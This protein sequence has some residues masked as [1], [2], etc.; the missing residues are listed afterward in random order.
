MQVQVLAFQVVCTSVSALEQGHLSLSDC[1]IRFV[2]NA[3]PFTI[4]CFIIKCC[5]SVYSIATL[6]LL[7]CCHASTP[8]CNSTSNDSCRRSIKL[9]P[10]LQKTVTFFLE[11]IYKVSLT[12]ITTQ[13]RYL[14]Q[15]PL[16]EGFAYFTNDLLTFHTFNRTLNFLP[17]RIRSNAFV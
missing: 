3:V 1:F 2:V 16:E 11:L 9:H 5:K 7:S 6:S 15:R 13:I 4:D 8:L 10:L 14:T 17:L 12:L